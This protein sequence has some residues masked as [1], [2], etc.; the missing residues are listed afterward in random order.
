MD[1]ITS[2]MQQIYQNL[3]SKISQLDSE[4]T[5]MLSHRYYG[6]EFDL[7]EK[8]IRKLK[9]ELEEIESERQIIWHDTY[10]I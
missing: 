8:E 4:L 2:Q 9:A 1:S 7:K 3:Q 5:T 6:A 10:F